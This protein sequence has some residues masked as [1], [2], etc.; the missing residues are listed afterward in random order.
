M[1]DPY[2]GCTFCPQLCRHTCPVV[3]ATGRE[4]ATPARIMALLREV[5]AGRAPAAEGA[6]AAALCTACGACRDHCRFHVDVPAILAE[7][8]GRLL[9]PPTP[10]P[11]RAVEGDAP[12]VALECD[13][14]A[15]S[16]AL[17]ERLGR[18]VARLATADH[19]GEALLDH[20]TLSAPGLAAWRTALAGR[21]VVCACGRC[22]AVLAAVGI[23]HT[24]L[25]AL[26][27]TAW[28][29]TSFACQTGR[30]LPGRVV[31][32]VALSCGGHGPLARVHPELARDLAREAAAQLPAGPVA[33]ADACCRAALRDAGAMA[34]D[35]IDR[36]LQP[37]RGEAL[38]GGTNAHRDSP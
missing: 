3:R 8:R 10:A 31:G 27:P 1:A 25:D 38:S 9:P 34:L 13:G 20:P 11:R 15:W 37:P 4:A 19:L 17:A 26:A 2:A 5:A 29:G 16:G 28:D 6:R 14:R 32:G 33:V 36:L 12:L 18:P 22:Q 23:V 21:V 7:A 35:P 30:A 24:W